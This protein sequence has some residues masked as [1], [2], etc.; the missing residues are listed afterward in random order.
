MVTIGGRR[1]GE[2][3]RGAREI[4]L[5]LLYENAQLVHERKFPVETSTAPP[6]VSAEFPL[7]VLV[8]AIII[9]SPVFRESKITAP[10]I[11]KREGGGILKYK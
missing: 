4:P 6:S 7:N 1:K 9:A 3:R 2:G 11:K 5:A 10:P 8:V